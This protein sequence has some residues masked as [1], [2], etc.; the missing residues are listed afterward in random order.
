MINVTAENDG[1]GQT[2]IVIEDNYSQGT[3]SSP[4]FTEKPAGQ[5]DLFGTMASNKKLLV[6]VVGIFV[7]YFYY[8]IIQEKITKSKYGQSKE[9]FT[10]T[11]SLVFFQCM[12]NAIF[13]YFVIKLTSEPNDTTPHRYY[14]ACGFSYIA[15]MIFSNQ[16]LQYVPYPTQVLG[17]SCKPI[18]IMILGVLVAQKRYPLLKYM[19]V[20][21]IV[22]G[23]SLFLYKDKKPTGVDGKSAFSLGF[24]EVLL[25][26]SL[27]MDGLT[28]A[29]QDKIRA[30]HTTRPY[31]MMM[32]MN[33]FSTVYTLLA[34]FATGEGLSFI[35]FVQR[36]PFILFNL[37]SFSFAS[38]L[39]QFFIFLTVA[40]FGPLTCSIVTTTRKFFTIL[41][42][43]LWFQNPMS[44]RQWLG[45]LM[46]F[47][48]LS[49]DSVYGKTKKPT[50]AAPKSKK[51]SSSG[52]V[53]R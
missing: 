24:G 39:G 9:P 53:V 14:A 21:L 33:V 50:A 52:G 27:A 26:A 7:C 4:P 19:F 1:D 34:L 42:S 16:A 48:G 11:I 10:Y 30:N 36:H 29:V 6:C 20:L 32:L 49:L 17:K 13:A 38:A 2:S 43:V 3:L 23:V 41:T 18:P 31:S 22:L 28:G 35:P 25:L 44:S 47:L 46:V 45:T 5:R 37:L 12:C 8:G 51:N 15:A 40:E